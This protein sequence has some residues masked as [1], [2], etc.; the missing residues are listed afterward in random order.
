MT[1]ATTF[2]SAPPAVSLRALL[3]P[4]EHGSWSLALEPLALALIVAPSGPGAALAG[5]AIA[6]FFARRPWQAARAGDA[7]LRT[8]LVALGVLATVALGAFVLGIA[9]APDAAATG[10]LLTTMPAGAAFAWFDRR[11]AGRDAA[12]ELCGAL[13]FALFAA[14]ITLAAGQSWT[15]AA[16]VGGFAAFRSGTTILTLRAFL[17]RRKGQSVSRLP[18]VLAATAGSIAFIVYACQT[19]CWL[20]AVWSSLFLLRAGWLLGP[21]TPNWSARRL[22]MVEAVLGVLAVITTGIA[23]R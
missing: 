13:F 18:A 6:L 20:P 16:A 14:A 9:Q 17:R 15:L 23:L 8:A 3:L 2:A 21:L 1:S 7:R 5:G 19:G 11:K 12:A 22:G 10:G 4:R